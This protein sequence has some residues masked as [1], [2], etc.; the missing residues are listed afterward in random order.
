MIE[1]RAIGGYRSL[2]DVRLELGR[3]TL[4]PGA[5]GSGKSSLY[6]ALR[7]LTDVA[8]RR[9]VASLAADGGLASAPWAG[10]EK[11]LRAMLAGDAPVQGVVRSGP[12][13]LRMGWASQDYGYAVDLGLPMPSRSIFRHDPEIKL[14][15]VWT[16]N[17]LGRA[18]IFAERKGPMVR[19]RDDA[20]RWAKVTTGLAST[21]SMMTHC[22]DPRQ[23]PELLVLREEF[24]A[25]RFYDSLR[26]DR[27]APVRQPYIGHFT[28]VLASDGGDLESA[29][30][31]IIEVGDR[32]GLAETI[33]EAFFRRAAGGDR[34]GVPRPELP[35]AATGHC[36]AVRWQIALSDAGGD[37]ALSPPAGTAD[38]QRSRSQLAPLSAAAARP[39]DRRRCCTIADY[40]RVVR[41]S[42]GL[43]PARSP[44]GDPFAA[45]EA[46][47]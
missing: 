9:L 14:E 32:E 3:L 2:R 23:A 15:S 18:N 25:W 8:Q 26:T 12:V 41:R 5:N 24:R 47:G 36:R 33:D 44:C 19:I 10:P 20:G 21:D 4:V 39:V 16:G 1:L 13:S 43:C 35:V 22:A 27:E 40:R 31:T 30:Q 29:I 6:W 46:A 11:F 17:T 28:P 34:G 37:P 45:G 42:A 38:S 7:L